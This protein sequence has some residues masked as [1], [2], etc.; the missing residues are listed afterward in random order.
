[1]QL[2]RAPRLRGHSRSLFKSHRT[3]KIKTFYIIL[4][5]KQNICGI[6]FSFIWLDLFLLSTFLKSV[7]LAWLSL[8]CY[9]LPHIFFQSYL[10]CNLSKLL[11]SQ[12]LFSNVNTADLFTV[13]KMYFFAVT[14]SVIFI[15][16]LGYSVPKGNQCL[17]Y[18]KDGIDLQMQMQM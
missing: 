2:P 12:R 11:F 16:S 8:F 7:A 6:I 10:I 15:L 3:G 13:S 14:Y 18:G 5:K 1:M 4:F 17:Y 9:F